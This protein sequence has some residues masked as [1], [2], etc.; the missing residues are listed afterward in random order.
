MFLNALLKEGIRITV[1][2]AVELFQH[3]RHDAQKPG[4]D[5]PQILN[6][7]TFSDPVQTAFQVAENCLILLMGLLIE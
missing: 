7:I 2:A 6:T 3:F 1:F 4:V 5:L